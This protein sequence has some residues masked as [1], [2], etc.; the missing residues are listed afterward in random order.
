MAREDFIKMSLFEFIWILLMSNDANENGKWYNHGQTT[1][2][3]S[4]RYGRLATV[5]VQVLAT[6]C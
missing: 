5:A 3:E 1:W 6:P 4:D 2:R